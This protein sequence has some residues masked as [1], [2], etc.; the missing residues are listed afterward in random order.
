[1][2]ITV[3]VAPVAVALGLGFLAYMVSKEQGE[4]RHRSYHRLKQL[5]PL[6]SLKIVIVVWQILTEVSALRCLSPWKVETN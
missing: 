4:R 3:M 1:M 2:L 6:Q 5:L